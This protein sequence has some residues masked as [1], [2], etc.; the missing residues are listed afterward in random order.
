MGKQAVRGVRR[1]QR[2]TQCAAPPP[3]PPRTPPQHT[4]T[5]SAYDGRRGQAIVPC[6]RGQFIA[7]GT[8]HG[9]TL[10]RATKRLKEEESKE[11]GE[12]EYKEEDSEEEGEQQ[13]AKNLEIFI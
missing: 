8:V 12:A 9:G 3:P 6:K 10:C 7:H 4:E 13:M 5:V 1:R 2:Q 11:E